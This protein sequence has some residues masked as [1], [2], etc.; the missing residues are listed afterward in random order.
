MTD[1][2]SD[3]SEPPTQLPAKIPLEADDRG[4]MPII[5]RNTDE[6]ARYTSAL[7]RAGIVPD[8]YRYS[9]KEATRAFQQGIEAR[10][11]DPN[12]SLMLAGILK[13]MELGLAPQTGLSTIYPVNG[14]FTVFGDGA[15]GLIQRD[16]V[17]TKQEA[18]RLGSLS[19]PGLELGDWP[20]DYG[21][22]VRFWRRHQDEPYIGRFTVRDARRANLWMRPRSPWVSYPDRMLFNRARAFSLRDGF[23]DCLMGL[24]IMEEVQDTLPPDDGVSDTAT[25]HATAFDDE[26]DTADPA[27]EQGEVPVDDL[28]A[29]AKARWPDDAT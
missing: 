13:A 21:W 15:V 8:S 3:D 17:I 22:E 28:M 12:P 9:A 24:G 1:E 2:R 25:R 19:V 27:L 4:I 14:K 23:A 5:P 6:A 16:R 10:E 7:I 18:V 20:D 11:G 26:P 29:E